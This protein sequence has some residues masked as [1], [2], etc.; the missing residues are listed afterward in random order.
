MKIGSDLSL[1]ARSGHDRGP[2][3]AASPFRGLQFGFYQQESGATAI[4]YAL[5]AGFVSLALIGGAT[6]IGQWLPK[7]FSNIA[8]NL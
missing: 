7:V 4:E 8:E 3:A 1:N 6:E 5:I 2:R